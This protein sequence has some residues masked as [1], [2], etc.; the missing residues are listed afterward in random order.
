MTGLRVVFCCSIVFLGKMA[1]EFRAV[2]TQLWTFPEW[3]EQR[4]I[5]HFG[6][7]FARAHS[8]WTRIVYAVTALLLVYFVHRSR[9]RRIEAALTLL[10]HQRLSER[11][12]LARDLNDTLL[13]TIEAGKLIADDALD[14]SSDPVRMREAMGR[15]SYWL[16]KATQE[17]QAALNSL[18]ATSCDGN[19]LASGFRRAAEECLIN[20]CI[21]LE[22]SV[23]GESKDMHPMVRDE[24]YLLG[25]EAISNAC[26]RSGIDRLAIALSYGRNFCMQVKSSGQPLSSVLAEKTQ[27]E[28][29][30]LKGMQRRANRFGA[31]A[32]LIISSS[33]TV[34][35]T[36]TVPGGIIFQ[37]APSILPRRWLTDLWNRFRSRKSDLS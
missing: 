34:E 32:S 21:I 24:V 8:V 19:D 3:I 13:Q 16:G 25:C 27:D 31:T 28:H 29:L 12:R 18:G 1:A 23:T 36:L 37:I 26:K 20:R 2:R 15:L 14:P 9:V 6:T 30:D 17:G 10:F 33:S 7:P 5:L 4:T 22:L 11:A 35:L